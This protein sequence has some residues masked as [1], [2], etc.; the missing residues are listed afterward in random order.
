[1][2]NKGFLLECVLY[3]YSSLLGK[4]GINL[5]TFQNL[6]HP[7]GWNLLGWQNNSDLTEYY[8]NTEEGINGLVNKIWENDSDFYAVWD[9]IPITFKLNGGGLDNG[10]S[11]D[12]VLMCPTDFST[13][14]WKTLYAT[15]FG[16]NHEKLRGS[17]SAPKFIGW[18][19]AADDI[20]TNTF[21]LS[22][23]KNISSNKTYYA[24]WRKEEKNLDAVVFSDT[25]LNQPYAICT[26][27]EDGTVTSFPDTPIK[28][29]YSFVQ[30]EGLQPNGSSINIIS[31]TRYINGNSNEPINIRAVWNKT[32]SD[33]T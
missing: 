4:D 21:T 7:Q 16:E 24:L 15:T 32:E 28:T 5:S 18:G 8:P 27:G 2:G 11:A 20:C 13:V 14:E 19:K 17:E 1:M 22:N 23:S 6:S 9:H 30:W 25:D 26:I 31:T 33:E 3:K 10:I 29:G 12:I